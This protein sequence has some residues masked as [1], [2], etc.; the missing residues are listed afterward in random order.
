MTETGLIAVSESAL[1]AWTALEDLKLSQN[2]RFVEVVYDV[3]CAS[4]KSLSLQ[5]TSRPWPGYKSSC[6]TS[7]AFANWPLLERL[8][9][10]GNCVNMEVLVHTHFPHLQ[11]LHLAETGFDACQPAVLKSGSWAEL[12]VLDLD[13]NNV[14]E[15]QAHA[16]IESLV[17]GQWPLR[18]VSTKES[19]VTSGNMQILLQQGWPP[20]IEVNLPKFGFSNTCSGQVSRDPMQ[21]GCTHLRV[22]RLPLGLEAPVM[23]PNGVDFL[24]FCGS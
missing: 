6:M 7:L 2:G 5:M 1:T 15:Y 12:E 3:V 22:I 24:F 20:L 8:D 4:L 10:T 21:R 14:S 11:T 18:V 16:S 19:K 23:T 13:R 9:L 17:Q